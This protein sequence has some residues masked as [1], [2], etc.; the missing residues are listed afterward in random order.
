M[1]N[2]ISQPDHWGEDRLTEH[3]RNAYQNRLAT[4]A[5]KKTEF[6][7]LIAIDACFGRVREGLINPKQPLSALLFLRTF[8]SY[9]SVCEAAAAG[10]LPETF[11]LVR[12]CLECA[13]YAL[14]IARVPNAGT[15]WLNRHD[16]AAALRAAKDMFTVAA[17]KATIRSANNKAAD[18]FEH[19]YG[20]AI[21]NGGHPNERAVTGNM[22][23]VEGAGRIEMQH[24]FLHGDGVQLDYA[25]I[26]A[27]RT[28]ICALVILKE[29][30]PERFD[31]LGVS[32]EILKLR[33]GL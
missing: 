13:G 30:F 2:P 8:A 7:K 5:N 25:L 23:L 29:I 17:V 4:F 12:A 28:G 26:T 32:D 21:D 15:V 22:T 14:H 27:A 9:R 18:I 33:R 16:D 31:L 6:G 20:T 11:G 1:Q 19:L 3:L 24:T 10:E